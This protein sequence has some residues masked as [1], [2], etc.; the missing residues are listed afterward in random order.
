MDP[1]SS[2]V[3]QSS[4]EYINTD[5]SCLFKLIIIIIIIIIIIGTINIKILFL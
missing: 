2:S 1:S 5:A 4:L 3:H